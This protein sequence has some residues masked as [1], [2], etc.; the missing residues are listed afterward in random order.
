MESNEQYFAE[1]EGISQLFRQK[2]IYLSGKEMIELAI[3]FSIGQSL[4]DFNLILHDQG[5]INNKIVDI[6]RSLEEI[7]ISLKD[8]NHNI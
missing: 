5:D 4:N 7:A 1:L 3:K 2:G 8:I 6:S